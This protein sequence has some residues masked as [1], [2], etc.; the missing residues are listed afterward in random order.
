MMRTILS[1]GNPRVPLGIIFVP[2]F[3][4]HPILLGTS[5]I[6]IQRELRTRVFSFPTGIAGNFLRESSATDAPIYAPQCFRCEQSHLTTKCIKAKQSTGQGKKTIFLT[7]KTLPT[8]VI[9]ERLAVYLE[10]YDA[11]LSQELVSG[12]AYGFTSNL[13]SA[14]HNPEIVDCKL[15]KEICEGRIRGPFIHIPLDNMIISALGVIPKKQP[16]EYRMIHHLS[17]PYGGSGNDFIP[18]E[19]CSVHYASVDDD[20]IRM[21]KRIGPSCT[22]AK[23][24]VRSAFRMIPVHPAD[25]Y[26]LGMHWRGNY[27]VDCCLPMGLASSCRT[28]E[29]LSTALEWVARNKLNTPHIH[30]LDDF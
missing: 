18:S 21:I 4:Y 27:Y 9:V 8:P 14:L 20:A 30:I 5:K 19:F 22:L 26:L 28:F 12:F 6:T 24:D 10:G 15:I 17:Y 13:Q 1:F 23:T 29:M 2:S 16:G 3:G 7:T 25:Y 11:Q